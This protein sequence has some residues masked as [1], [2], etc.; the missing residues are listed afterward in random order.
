MLN[1]G[2]DRMN[3]RGIIILYTDFSRDWL[4]LLRVC[5]INTLGLHALYCNGG[6]EGLVKWLS[7]EEVRKDIEFFEENGIEVEYEMHA[8]DWLLPRSL[9]A[10][11]PDWFR[12]ND[13]GERTKDWNCC[14]SN[15]E[16]LSYIESS[17]FRYA[18]LL[19]QKSHNYYIWRDD[20]KDGLCHCEL[21]RKYNGADQNM[22]V[23]KYILKGIKQ[24][25]PQ[26]KLS[27]LTYQD[28]F[29]VPLIT[30]D[31][32]MFLEFAPIERNHFVS[33]TARDTQNE[34][35]REI[36]ER[37]LKIFPAETAQALEYFLDVSLFCQWQREKAGPLQI[38][39][40]RL[41]ADVA[42]YSSLG[43][44]NI[45]TF[46]AFMDCEWLHRYGTNAIEVYG[47]IVNEIG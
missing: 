32:D 2:V 36:L 28:S 42:Y 8:L 4:P 22:L 46:A 12:M 24:Y 15:E 19:A 27:F 37:L 43:I 16:G 47:K 1:Y 33:I 41:N 31:K 11:H 45:S 44:K 26:A 9:F 18:K 38:D 39:E 5:G 10:A 40:K 13:I 17:A 21:C 30:P 3:K 14:V 23:M 25:D 29:D 35:N 6:V 7:N 34:K 20:T